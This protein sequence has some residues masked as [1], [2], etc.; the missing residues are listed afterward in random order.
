MTKI[1]VW[2]EVESILRKQHQ[3]VITE[4]AASLILNFSIDELHTKF[5]TGPY[6]VT[7]STSIG[8]GIE[9]EIKIHRLEKKQRSN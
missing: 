7:T 5:G 8:T 6:G 3:G 2:K 4:E 1:K 9:R